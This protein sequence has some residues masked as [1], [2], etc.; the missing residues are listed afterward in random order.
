[1]AHDNEIPDDAAVLAVLCQVGRMR[2]AVL[3]NALIN[4]GYDRDDS[5]RAIRRCLNRDLIRLG[6]DLALEPTREMAEAA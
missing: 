5:Q 2:A 1:M 3:L 4:E 6:S